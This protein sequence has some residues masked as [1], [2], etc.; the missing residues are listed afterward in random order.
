MV[1]QQEDLVAQVASDLQLVF[2]QVGS[3]LFSVVHMAVLT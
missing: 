1:E 3:R 2:Q